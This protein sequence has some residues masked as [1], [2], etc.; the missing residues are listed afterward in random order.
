[1]SPLSLS[2][3]KGLR[4]LA[5]L[6]S[7][8]QEFLGRVA[9]IVEDRVEPY[10]REIPRY[11]TT[12]WPGLLTGLNQLF[13]GEIERI[14]SEPELQRAEDTV[15][16]GQSAL[17]PDAPFGFF[18][19]GDLRLGR[20]CY[21]LARVMR[22][23][24]VVET[25]VCYGVTSAFLLSALAVNGLGD[26]HSID[27][28]PLGKS[29][30]DF[31]GRLV[32]SELRNRWILHRGRSQDILP[33]L[34]EKLV[35]VD[36]FVHDSLHTY[37]NMRREFDLVTPRLAKD[38]IVIADDVEGNCAFAEWVERTSPVHSAVVQEQSKQT[39]LGIAVFRSGH[40]EAR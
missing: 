19:N 10:L 25:G 11:Q 2:L 30:E 7:K 40:G 1:L 6:P 31:V 9:T 4:L 28:P 34:L 37:R 29:A 18:H 12:D 39:L 35:R 8:P 38:A 3:E 24:V 15:V 17:G 22:P 20:L 23:A 36:C 27:L 21:A 33:G 13:P 14:F 16:R 32:P 5:I 26:L